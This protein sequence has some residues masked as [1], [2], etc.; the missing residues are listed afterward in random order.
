MH[1]KKTQIGF[2]LIELMMTLA[3][4]SIVVGIAT[5]SFQSMISNSRLT[6][7]T[8]DFVSALSLARSEAV[9]RSVRVTVL[10]KGPTAGAW[11]SG[12]DVFVDADG[13]NALDPNAGACLPNADCLLR[14]Y[15]GLPAGYTLTTGGSYD[16]HAVFLPNGLSGT[17]IGDTF[18]L[19]D[20]THD[21]GQ[22]RKIIV[23][24]TGRA[25]VDV[26]P[27]DPPLPVNCP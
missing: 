23:N 27:Y 15:D 19:C 3:I 6:A 8:N 22:S 24:S 26:P 21:D 20:G 5:P 16:D 14:T 11:E 4:A 2:T 25:R 18:T 13:D 12:W 10:R 9:K 1:N 7:S 17:P